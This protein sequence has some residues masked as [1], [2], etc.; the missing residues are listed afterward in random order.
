MTLSVFFDDIGNRTQTS[1]NGRSAAYSPDSLNQYDDRAVPRFVDVRGIASATASVTVNSNTSSRLGNNFHHPLDLS[2]GGNGAQLATINVT[3]MLPDGGDNNTPRV[4]DADDSKFLRATPEIFSHDADGNLTQDGQWI[5]TWD[6]NN[7]LTSMETVAAA[8]AVGIPRKKLEFDYDSQGRRFSKKVYDWDISSF[9]LTTGSLY[10]YDGWNLI[11]ELDTATSVIYGTYFWGTDLSG[12]FQGAGGVGGLL[13]VTDIYQSTSYPTYDGNGN[14]MGYYASDSGVKLA[15]FEYGPFGEKIR[16]N[17]YG[18]SQGQAF[19]FSWSTKYED[20]ET[21]LLYYGYRYY[22]AETGRWL[23]KDPIEEQGG[24]NLYGMV[25]NDA[26]NGFDILGLVSDESIF[27]D[28]RNAMSAC[29]M[30]YPGVSRSLGFILDDFIN[31]NSTF[32]DAKVAIKEAIRKSK[33]GF[34]EVG[35]SKQ[36]T[37]YKIITGIVGDT[38]DLDNTSE[39]ELIRK[40]S[41][42]A[43]NS[44]S[45]IEDEF[46]FANKT[47]GYIGSGIDIVDSATSTNKDAL[48]VILAVS[49][50]V[51]NFGKLSGPLGKYYNRAVKGVAQGLE[52]FGRADIGTPLGEIK[53]FCFAC[54]SKRNADFKGNRDDFNDQLNLIRSQLGQDEIF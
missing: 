26:V 9:V 54:N 38:T 27:V 12:S 18:S 34:G 42:R 44:L 19:A 47:L 31:S 8:Y 50:I 13:A 1:T 45:N 30:F 5:Y 22:N 25:G 2:S 39:F 46:K 11:V 32:S 51:E 37:A 28:F 41:K 29:S 35:V 48:N 24:V 14:V 21:G 3:A 4:A 43:N 6:A 20:M 23:N 40:L 52:S 10:I 36:F 53:G 7:R 15:D 49:S 16:E 33:S 17:V